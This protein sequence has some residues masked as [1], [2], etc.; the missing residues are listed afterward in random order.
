[1]AAISNNKWYQWYLRQVPLGLLELPAYEMDNKGHPVIHYGELFCRVQDC[2]KGQRKFTA[3]NNLRTHLKSHNGITL[4]NEDKGGRVSQKVQDDAI[5]WYRRLFAGVESE[6][7]GPASSAVSP[8]GPAGPAN[9]SLPALP[10]K[11]KDN[12]VHTTNMRQLVR[13][14]GHKVPCNSCPALKDC[15]KDIN[16]CDHFLLFDC[17]NLAPATAAAA[18][19]NNEGEEEA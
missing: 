12:T 3:T 14:M 17:G 8:A 10:L 1:M 13:N 19:Q 2:S 6:V 4:D 15:C 18:S 5:R 11:Q 9:A 16:R 7:Q